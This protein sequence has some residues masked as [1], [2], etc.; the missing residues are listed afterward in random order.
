MPRIREN[1]TDKLR[2]LRINLLDQSLLEEGKL[3]TETVKQIKI[4]NWGKGDREK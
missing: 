2:N 1:W 3:S 4:N